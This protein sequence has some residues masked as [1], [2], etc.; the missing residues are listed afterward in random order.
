MY[1]YLILLLLIFIMMIF[2][3]IYVSYKHDIGYNIKVTK[4]IKPK[5]KPM[6]YPSMNQL[7]NNYKYPKIKYKWGGC[8]K[9][10]PT[11]G[12]VKYWN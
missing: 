1:Q 11:T 12:V 5:I 3:Y 7:Y 9:N 8:S 10:K 4:K 2:I 6:F